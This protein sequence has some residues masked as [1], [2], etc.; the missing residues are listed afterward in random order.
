[1]RAGLIQDS[2]V[3]LRQF[4][5]VPQF[6]AAAVLS[7]ALSIGATTG[8]FSVIYGVLFN[9]YPYKDSDRMVHVELS[10]PRNPS[11]RGAL[12]Q[13]NGAEYQ[14]LLRASSLDDVFL[15]NTE[16]VTLTG[17]EF[18]VTVAVG[19]CTPNVFTFMGVDPQLG[20]EFTPADVTDGQTAPIAVLSY[21]FWQKQFSGNPGVIGQNIELDHKLYITI[22]VVPPRFTWG[23]VDVYLAATA[24][25][26]PHELWPAFVKL[27]P[28][29]QR[30]AA[31][32]ELQILIDRFT[33]NNAEDSRRGSRVAL[34][35]LN[36]EVLGRFS[37]TLILLFIAVLTLLIIGCSNL[38]I[39]LLARGTA[40][41]NELAVRASIGAS[42]GRLM[43]QLLIESMLLS[44][45]GSALGVVAA[46]RSVGL[47]SAM[48]PLYAF[49]HEAVI[50]VNA[51]VLLFSA[52][53][54]LISGIL[55]GI[56]PAWQ[57]S[58]PEISQLSQASS[59]RHSG[60]VQ[61][62][63]THRLL[64]AGQ[65]ALTLLLMTGAG[66]AIRSFLSLLHTPLGFDP[67][68]LVTM[69]VAFPQ[70]TNSTW[71]ARF[72]AQ[73]AVRQ[74]V[75]QTPGVASAS[76]SN[77]FPPFGA[78]TAPIGIRSEPTLT[79]AQAMLATASPQE[80]ATLR[81]P[82]LTGRVFT[83]AEINGAAHVALVN[84]A[85]VKQFLQ[86]QQPI[87]QSV[88][89]P[90]LNG[91]I[92]NLF[93]VP[94]AD[95]WLEVVGVLADARDDGLDRPVKPAVFIP[96]SFVLPPD[97]SMVARTNGDPD[98]VIRSIKQHLHKLN[99]EIVVTQSH[100]LLWSLDTLRE[101]WG[102]GRFLAMIFS[103]FA[104]LALLLAATGLYSVVRFAVS[105]RTQELGI[106]IA[107][108]APRMRVLQLVVRSTAIPLG[109]G[110]LAGIGLSTTLSHAVAS[111]SGV[112]P[113]SP[114]TLLGAALLL[115][116]VAMIAC[117]LPAW[118]A[119]TMKPMAALR[120]E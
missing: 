104:L 70:G 42:R 96:Y 83:A 81:I 54:A 56:S 100:T 58:R 87:G 116:M 39:L 111:W 77:W 46:Y 60:N 43:R 51:P 107:L 92:P 76:V 61:T 40:R 41:Q 79:D 112:N 64:I 86:N 38:S 73:E 75:E 71:E 67:D 33:Q 119:A 35:T 3:A 57:L 74:A 118:R 14:Q 18:P 69:N 36:Q 68:H 9:P 1:M 50:R 24:P 13:V 93:M 109:I 91:R 59:G 90:V 34:I 66:A 19:H 49:P 25:S 117:V 52:A 22:G 97:V 44:L 98:A 47:I 15:M 95:G 55:F 10:D 82:L 31:A 84:E 48:L 105:Q 94:G 103:L 80:F 26:D 16:S 27:K 21:Q 88:R 53:M 115:V 12:L 45:A 72:N 108:G 30:D 101:G 120:Y 29:R 4:W 8:I 63:N 7:M 17:S 32:S 28:G 78:F 85:F 110:V 65:I 2:H 114:L 99:A 102:Q 23:D 5:R 6:S 113:G 62:R 11:N 106:R 20:R 89:S 37:G